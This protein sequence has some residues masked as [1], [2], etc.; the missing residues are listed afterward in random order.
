MIDRNSPIPIYYQLKQLLKGQIERGELR[1]GDRVPTEQELCRRYQISRAPV[2]Q[3]LAGLVREG[4]IYRRAGQG[5]FVAQRLPEP[6]VQHLT[7]NLFASDLRWVALMEEAV[8]VWNEEHGGRQ[9]KLEIKLPSRS[10][11]HRVF[12]H[13]VV[14]G[15][16]PDLVSIDYVWMTHYARQ[17]YVIP[18]RELS[19][20]FADF[21]EEELDPPVR[22]SQTV[23]GELYSVPIQAD[24]T[25]LWYRKDWFAAEGVEPP[26]T[27]EA[28]LRLLAHFAEDEVRTRWGYRAPLAFPAGRR[29]GEAT[30]NILLPFIWAAG[31]TVQREDGSM[32]V[33][34]PAVREALRFLRRLTL[35]EGYVLPECAQMPWWGVPRALGRGEVAMSLGGTYEWPTIAEEVEWDGE[36]EMAQHLGF[37]PIPRLSR[38]IPPVASL[39][40]TTWALPR[41]GG[42]REIVLDLLRYVT[43]TEVSQTFCERNLQIAPLRSVNR[44]LKQGGHPW[45]SSVV[46]L[47]LIARPRPMT[48]DYITRS[49]ILQ[50]F[51]EET[52]WDRRPLDEALMLVEYAL[53]LCG[54][55][56]SR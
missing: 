8:S 5:T 25:G 6:A 56:E 4:Y 19:P 14:A 37:V 7:L 17:G 18:V 34:D 36:E 9:V 32:T 53:A 41:Q 48:V 52:L 22:L 28:F 47:L 15:E 45:L 2:R 12:H 54:A 50:H 29:A 24:V 51:F 40:G 31:G 39:G 43:R 44:R 16:S 23:E 30:V 21:L 33:S 11:V 49:R 10:R 42:R 38:E 13:A 20:G 26:Q 1:P 46:P 27:W 35:E 3:A 55:E